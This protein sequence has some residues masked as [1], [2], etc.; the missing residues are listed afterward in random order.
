VNYGYSS[1]EHLAR[2]L[3][4]GSF[5]WTNRMAMYSA[6]FDESGHPDRGKYLV[7]AGCIA[8]IKQW[9]E[10]EREWKRE[11]APFGTA[12]FHTVD[13]DNGNR[14]F[15]QLTECEADQL[16]DRLVGIICRRIEKSISRATQLDQHRAIDEKYVFSECHGFPYPA[17]ARSCMAE[18]EGW[19]VKHSIPPNEVRYFFEDGA[20][21][22]GQLK[23]IAE[24]DRRLGG[25][26]K[27]AN[28]GHVKTGQRKS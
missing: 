19:A 28:E 17:A 11:L 20:K 7:V 21:H 13:F 22:K 1:T 25:H 27:P 6:Y 15:D 9:V 3:W 8:D 23:W 16:F 2:S 24:R 4:L 14:P 18:V 10:F 5:K 12:L 26:P